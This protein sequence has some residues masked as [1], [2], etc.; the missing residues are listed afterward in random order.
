MRGLGLT[1]AEICELAG[2]CRAGRPTRPH[3][4]ELL[5]R[6][7]ERL[8]QRIADQH[9]MLARIEAFEAEYHTELAVG[10]E[11]PWDDDPRGC[12]TRG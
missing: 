3:L 9:H 1:V 4:V 10:G 12:A 2:E 6:S 11:V 8:T 5:R 7:R